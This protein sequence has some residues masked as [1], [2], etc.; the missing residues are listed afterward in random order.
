MLLYVY[1][2]YRKQKDT[3]P[4]FQY[5]LYVYIYVCMYACLLLTHIICLFL[6]FLSSAFAMNTHPTQLV[7][8]LHLP[9]RQWTLEHRLRRPP[10]H[11]LLLSTTANVTIPLLT[12]TRWKIRSVWSPFINLAWWTMTAPKWIPKI[13]TVPSAAWPPFA[14]AKQ[15]LSKG[16]MEPVLEAPKY[17]CM[18]CI[19]TRS[20]R[21]RN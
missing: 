6:S 18:A 21:S 2:I 14:F 3:T 13:P 10:P 20:A 19:Y 5:V 1:S 15:R 12:T 4:V 8:T 17:I 9:Q 11:P 16:L 7:A